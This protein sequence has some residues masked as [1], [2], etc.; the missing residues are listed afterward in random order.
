[1]ALAHLLGSIPHISP[2]LRKAL[3]DFL[4][5]PFELIVYGRSALVLGYPE[6]PEEFSIRMDV[7]AILYFTHLFEQS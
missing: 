2:L 6:S 4:W 7:D 3:D 5:S 1:M